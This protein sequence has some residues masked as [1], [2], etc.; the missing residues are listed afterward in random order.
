MFHY[1]S[2]C[3]TLFPFVSVVSFKVVLWSC[4]H[5]I[6][7]RHGTPE[8]LFLIH[9]NLSQDVTSQIQRTARDVF[10]KCILSLSMMLADADGAWPGAAMRLARGKS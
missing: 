2:L 4:V 9:I 3:F 1:V 7:L 8:H 5:W 6:S 10:A